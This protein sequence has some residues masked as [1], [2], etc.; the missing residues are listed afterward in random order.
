MSSREQII[1]TKAMVQQLKIKKLSSVRG[2]ALLKKKVDAL[3][4]HYRRLQREI[5]EEKFQMLDMLRDSYWSIAV[6]Q[7]S[8]STDMSALLQQSVTK[9]PTSYIISSVQNI[10]GVRLPQLE[11]G[12]DQNAN[13]FTANLGGGAMV[14]RQA[15]EKWQACLQQMVKVSSIQACYVA[16]EDVIL[17][18]N[19]RVNALEYVIIPALEDNIKYIEE[20]LEE[21]EREGFFK[22]K[23]VSNKKAKEAEEAGINLEEV[24]AQKKTGLVVIETPQN[25]PNPDDDLF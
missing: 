12:K 21:E 7:R 14:L 6:S 22:M 20:V 1:P 11:L 25:K 10:A 8:I 24:E 16:L 2:H 17:Q 15:S 3:N 18:T 4:S 23:M 19:R 5:K 13:E 9:I